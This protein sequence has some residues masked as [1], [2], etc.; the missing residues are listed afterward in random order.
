MM[1]MMMM[2]VIM[3]RGRGDCPD[4]GQ[5]PGRIRHRLQV[6]RSRPRHRPRPHRGGIRR[7][8]RSARDNLDLVTAFLMLN[9][10]DNIYSRRSVARGWVTADWSRQNCSN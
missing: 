10:I 8:L 5:W 2:M 9:T 4:R 3:T 7:Q 1:V 6:R